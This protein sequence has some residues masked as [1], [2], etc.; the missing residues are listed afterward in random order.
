MRC[1]LT[2]AVFPLFLY[3]WTARDK[4]VRF[5]DG[6]NLLW[7][8]VTLTVRRRR[9]LSKRVYQTNYSGK[10]SWVTMGLIKPKRGVIVSFHLR[11]VACSVF[12]ASW[13]RCLVGR[14]WYACR[15]RMK[16]MC[17]NHLEE[18]AAASSIHSKNDD[19]QMTSWISTQIFLFLISPRS[20]RCDV[21]LK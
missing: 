10:R 20:T 8:R 3:E 14:I 6:R 16:K 18:L 19:E 9:R 7:S 4:G 15:I 17:V 2:F 1:R 12:H 11:V 13:S 5:G 21:T